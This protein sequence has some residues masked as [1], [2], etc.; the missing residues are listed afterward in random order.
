MSEKKSEKKQTPAKKQGSKPKQATPKE[1]VAK[2]DAAPAVQSS[3]AHP[4]GWLVWWD[5]RG[6]EVAGA[7]FEKALSGI[8]HQDACPPPMSPERRLTIAMG[9]KRAALAVDFKRAGRQDGK[10]VFRPVHTER[11]TDTTTVPGSEQLTVE[12][13]VLS[14][15]AVHTETGEL[16]LGDATCPVS[17]VVAQEYHRLNGKLM[18]WDISSGIVSVLFEHHGI[19]LRRNGGM[20]FVPF[21][22]DAAKAISGLSWII[23]GIDGC[24]IYAPMLPDS[25]EWTRAARSASASSLEGQYSEIFRIAEGFVS[26]LDAGEMVSGR[27]LTSRVQAVKELRNRMA[28]FREILADRGQALEDASS[29]LSTALGSILEKSSE[30]RSLLKAKDSEK[31]QTLAKESLTEIAHSTREAL[32]AARCHYAPVE[33]T[34]A[35]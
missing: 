2:I 9:R 18:A 25:E 4:L 34:E 15:I 32:A 6:A 7:D 26:T 21:S 3:E 20:Y 31:A 30:V 22:D 11:T 12:P 24:E 5:L 19:A 33:P 17:Q 27:S 23:S 10:T 1:A 16:T 28:F 14:S 29:A 35:E 8:G 13:T